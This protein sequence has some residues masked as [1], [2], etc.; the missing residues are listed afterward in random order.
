MEISTVAT[1]ST[2]VTAHLAIVSFGEAAIVFVD[3]RR[4]WMIVMM[5]IVVVVH[6]FLPLLAVL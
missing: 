5:L 3:V 6:C 2:E 1:P 4:G